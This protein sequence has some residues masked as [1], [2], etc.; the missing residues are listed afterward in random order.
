MRAD[1]G[2]TPKQKR[3]G[4]LRAFKGSNYIKD[5]FA[6]LSSCTRFWEAGESLFSS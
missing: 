4:S 6:A 2:I 1:P 3:R 5:Y